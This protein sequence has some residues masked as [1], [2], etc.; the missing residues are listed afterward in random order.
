MVTSPLVTIANL[1]KKKVASIM[2][3]SDNLIT[4]QLGFADFRFFN[5]ELK[6]TDLAF[7]VVDNLS[8]E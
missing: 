3:V 2:A 6:M 5:A 1:N 4:G 8:G 7:Q